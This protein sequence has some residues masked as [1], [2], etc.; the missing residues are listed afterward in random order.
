MTSKLLFGDCAELRSEKVDPKLSLESY[1]IGLEHIEQQTLS[2][3]GHGYGSDVDSQKQRFHG[4]DILFGKL[5]PYF[6]K[7]VIAPFDGICSTD[8]WVVKPKAGVDRNFL[9]YW[10][11]SEEFIASSM[12]ASEGGRMPRAK[13][14]WVCKFELEGLTIDEQTAIGKVLRVLDQ[15][16][17]ANKA[18]SKTLEDIAQTIFKSWFID[19]D[20]V[21]AK[22]AGA[23]PVGMDA[24]TAALFPDSME[25]SELGLVPKD[26]GVSDLISL[27]DSISDGDW[28]ESKDQSEEGYRLLQIG[29]IGLGAFVESGKKKYV[30][31]ETFKRLRCTEIMPGD[32]LVARMPDPTG[33]SWYVDSLVEP[34]ITS[35]D[36]AIIRAN[37]S[38]HANRY[39]SMFLNL[40]STLKLMESLQ[41]GSTRQRV[42]R[43]YIETL[44]I[45]KPHAD[46]LTEF[47]KI[48]AKLFGLS[49]SLTKEV[50]ALKKVRDSL[51]P[52]LIS[53]EL[54]IPEEM[55]AS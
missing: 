26:W 35:V 41:T 34:A 1:Y 28:I 39:V 25:E 30:N 31:Q 4:G 2:L 50:L 6:R 15:K 49:D 5:R 52:R 10:M 51:M 38:R 43:T 14:D 11:A 22:I 8:I 20:P 47:D 42:K 37:S 18:L 7:V 9:F 54:Q 33:R 53:G 27:V 17:A 24:A 45:I 12:Y 21:K 48:T 16:I 36:V 13:W 19:F 40:P 32:V 29:N 46:V 44:R 23:K 3:V 55:L